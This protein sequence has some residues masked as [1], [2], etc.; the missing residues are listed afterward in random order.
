M[1][2][3]TRLRTASASRGNYV[4]RAGGLL[5]RCACG[6]SKSPVTDLCDDC[7]SKRLQRK[8][9]VGSSRDPLELEADRVADMVMTGSGHSAM[10]AAPVRI[11]RAS[12]QSQAATEAAPESVEQTL[13]RPGRPLD[14]DLRGDMEA[15][16]GYDFG[17]VRV[18]VGGL[19]DQ[20]A[21]DVN[22]NAYAVGHDLVFGP[23]R[24]APDT[25]AGRRLLAHELAHVVQQTQPGFAGRA[26]RQVQRDR[27]EMLGSS[28]SGPSLGPTTHFG[29][30]SGFGS[31]SPSFD[32][33]QDANL[34][35]WEYKG[36]PRV[37]PCPNCHQAGEQQ[38]FAS[39]RKPT[40]WTKV[41]QGEL[42]QWARDRVWARHQ[43]ERWILSML[44][45]QQDEKVTAVWN[46]HRDSLVS[47][48]R[49]GYDENKTRTFE[50]SQAAKDRWADF[51]NTQ[52]PTVVGW[53]NEMA[54]N[55]LV[56]EVAQAKSLAGP[57]A[58]L[59]TDPQTYAD[60]EDSPAHGQINI[61]GA[62]NER[63]GVGFLWLGRQAVSVTNYVMHFQVL[64]HPRIYF[65]MG[66]YE[67]NQAGTFAAK[68]FGDVAKA[69]EGI[70]VVG[71]FVK[72]VFNTV[73][74]VGE[75][76]IDAGAKLIDMQTQF[77]AVI[78]KA[79]GWYHVGYSCLSSTCK[80][81]QAGVSQ[82]ELLMNAIG[83]AT[84]VVP[85]V[86]Q[87]KQC[88]GEG[89]AEACGGLTGAALMAVFP[90]KSKRTAAIEEALIRQEINR[91]LG[92]KALAAAE[93]E[94]A[95]GKRPKPKEEAAPKLTERET[96]GGEREHGAVK[97]AVRSAEELR[98]ETAVHDAAAHAGSE[99][100][101]GNQ[102]HGVA[103]YGKGELGGFQLCTSCAR[104]AEK[105]KA[106]EEILPPGSELARNVRFVKER[107]MA[108]D[109][110]YRAKQLKPEMVEQAAKN[111]ASDLKNSV[112]KDP[113]IEQLLDMDLPDLKKNRRA[114]KKQAES[115]Q[116]PAAQVAV[117]PGRQATLGIGK[118][119]KGE[120]FKSTYKEA[121]QFRDSERT[122]G[123][124]L[125]AQSPGWTPQ[126]RIRHQ[127]GGQL[128]STVPEYFKENVNGVSIAVEV[129]NVSLSDL[130]MNFSGWAEQLARRINTIKQNFPGRPLQNWM[131]ADLRG[132]PVEVD[133]SGLS[134]RLKY[135]VAKAGR[136]GGKPGPSYDKVFFILDDRIVE[137]P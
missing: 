53:L 115:M 3:G 36:E 63:A 99:V 14:P 130:Q 49:L 77:V 40:G 16:F 48:V 94:L 78:G 34:Y 35:W 67:L 59:V 129:K 18:H 5:R 23:G 80:Q 137:M 54:E 87:A 127:P 6:S 70:A 125:E 44:Q 81:Y 101:I 60:I 68:V 84:V 45:R 89:N 114:L 103:A 98:V 30:V 76:V 95:A 62:Y 122:A 41:V 43:N 133:L 10:S 131:V 97:Q 7:R 32:A 106:L 91:P 82:S 20:S 39:N 25:H 29:A 104:L 13:A 58:T 33:P 109:R 24:F 118:Y 51:L 17:D 27:Y 11:H 65:E 61:G 75:A 31:S 88:F 119:T 124:A 111:L 28:Q 123:Q 73:A 126:G 93:E 117:R 4:T 37:L 135:G 132:L 112:V 107:A 83:D 113:F 1:N 134:A 102:K 128:L 15:R 66:T 26:M 56:Q 38:L 90:M 96:K 64:K 47:T 100:T 85:L 116:L 12:A 8:L 136:A 79:T 121:P 86:K 120:T 108:Y 55:W 42:L 21:R 2:A 22:A 92:R 69:A 105:L 72:G 50:G 57:Y 74:G 9:A 71:S 52:W 110:A 19:A 46:S